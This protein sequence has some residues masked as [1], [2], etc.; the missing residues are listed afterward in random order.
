M[1][2]VLSYEE[3]SVLCGGSLPD[4][5]PKVS[6]S[7]SVIRTSRFSVFYA[8]EWS[9]NGQSLLDAPETL[10]LMKLDLSNIEMKQAEWEK[11]MNN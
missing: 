1:V 10:S 8:F 11:K 6:P 4:Y 3:A 5:I 7:T 2:A 9:Y